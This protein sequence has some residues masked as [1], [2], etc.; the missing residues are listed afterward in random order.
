M[1]EGERKVDG[2]YPGQHAPNGRRCAFIHSLTI[3]RARAPVAIV[4]FRHQREDLR[5]NEGEDEGELA[6]RVACDDV[7]C[8]VLVF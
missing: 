8:F 2:A 5:A 6:C 1:V 4:V 7:C 3:P